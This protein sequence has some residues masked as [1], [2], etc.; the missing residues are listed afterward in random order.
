MVPYSELDSDILVKDRIKKKFSD[1]VL[2]ASLN[3]KTSSV[4]PMHITNEI[5]QKDIVIK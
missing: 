5:S 1:V 4:V 2:L 3:R